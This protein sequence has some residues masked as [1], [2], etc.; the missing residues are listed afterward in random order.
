MVIDFSSGFLGVELKEALLILAD[1]VNA[2][3]IVA[4]RRRTCGSP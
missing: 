2:E 1:L 4:A 3:V